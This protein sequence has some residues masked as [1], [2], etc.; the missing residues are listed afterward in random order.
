MTR[1]P[2]PPGPRGR[3]LSGHLPDLRRDPLGLYLRTAREYGDVATLR[4]G[5]RRIHLVSHPD[6]VEEVLVTRARNFTKHYGLR[7]NRRL[8]GNGLLTSEGD[9]WL[10]QRRLVQPAFSRERVAS[11]AAVMVGYADRLTAGWRDGETRDLHADM[12]RL[13]LEIIAKTLFDADVAGQARAVGEAMAELAGAFN[14]RFT[15]LLRLPAMLPTPANLRRERAARR[16]D[17]ILYELIKQRRTVRGRGDLLGTLL[18]AADEADGTGMTDRQLRD[19]AMTLFLAGHE[20]TAL[21]LSWTWH[22]LARHPEAAVELA[23]EVRAVLGGR[24][25]AADDLPRLRYAEMVVQ[26]TMRLYPPAYV[27]GRQAVEECVLGGY[28]IPAGGTV[29]MSQY[30]LHRDPRFFDDP[31]RF[32]PGRWADGLARRLPKYAYFPFGGGPRVCIGNTFALMEAVLVVAAVAR[33]FRFTAPAGPPPR[34]RPAI[35]LRPEGPVLLTV[36]AAPA[37]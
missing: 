4:F 18:E 9:F 34:P 16:L 37:G 14:A 23:E 26:E 2:L 20:T 11:Y 15:S 27:I 1:P 3:L 10:R 5:F 33:R 12:T 6:L 28:H 19:E 30:V 36:H 32:F 17:G 31:E 22:L 7:M 24:P 29:L 35:T 13:T 25:P 21:A 8:L